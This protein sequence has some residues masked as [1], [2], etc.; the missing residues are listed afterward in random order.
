MVAH[1]DDHGWPWFIAMGGHGQNTN[2]VQDPREVGT[3]AGVFR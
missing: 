1:G 3:L 2:T